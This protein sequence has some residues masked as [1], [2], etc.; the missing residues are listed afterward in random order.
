[1]NTQP[2]FITGAERSGASLVARILSMSGIFTGNMNG[3]YENWRLKRMA[4]LCPLDYNSYYPFSRVNDIPY[5][6]KDRVDREL[7]NQGYKNN[8]HWMF[9]DSSVTHMWEI[10]NH[11]YPNAK[12]VIV[13]RKTPDIINSCVK[14]HYMDLF[15]NPA[16]QKAVGVDTE[17]AGWLWWIHKY[18][19]Q[20][21]KMIE[22]GLNVRMVWPERMVDGDYSQIKDTLEWIGLKWSPNIV[23]TI[24]PLINKRK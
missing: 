15:K 21:V 16:I 1:M 24:D 2:V 10:W 19:E 12:W 7:S 6:W 17:E 8:R 3:M 18:E 13:R 4:V 5:D 23:H 20:W 22:Q 14:T 11:Y 9:K